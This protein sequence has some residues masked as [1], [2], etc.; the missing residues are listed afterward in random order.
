MSGAGNRDYT[1]QALLEYAV[2]YGAPFTLMHC[3]VELK[4]CPKW[5]HVNVLDFEVNAQEKNKRYKSSGSSCFSTTQSAE[6]R[7]NL[8]VQ[9]ADEEDDE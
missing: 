6:G 3:W 5:K 2:K 4:D 9:A 1:H 7:F 8:N